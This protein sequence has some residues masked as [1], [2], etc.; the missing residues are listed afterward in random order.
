VSIRKEKLETSFL[1]LLDK[2]KP[3]PESLRLFRAV[4]G[5]FWNDKHKGSAHHLQ[6]LEKQLED[7]KKREDRLEEAYI[8]ERAID[9]TTYQ[10]QKAKLGQEIASKEL[11]IRE[12]RLEDLDLTGMLD[13]AF[14]VISNPGKLWEH[15][16]LDGK[17]RLQKV[18]FPNGLKFGKAGFG[19]AETAIIYTLL[20]SSTAS[21]ETLVAPRGIETRRST[22][23]NI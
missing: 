12:N 20:S 2:L 22:R 1:N 3:T 21:N 14:S 19:T 17:Q 4:V 13:F 5:D 16:G 8:Y 10:A 23:P 7:L 15:T 18:L 9:P 6:T 11:E